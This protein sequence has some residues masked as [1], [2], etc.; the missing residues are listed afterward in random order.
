MAFRTAQEALAAGSP[1][2]G[3]LERIREQ[4]NR[5]HE[6]FLSAL[7][8][9]N[10]RTGQQESA[11]VGRQMGAAQGR[12]MGGGDVQGYARQQL[13]AMGMNDPREWDSLF[14]LW[15]KESGWNPNAVN[16]GSGAFGIAQILPSAHPTANRNMSAQEQIDWGLNYIRNR[17][18]SP[19]QAWAHSQRTNW[20]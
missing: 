1:D 14:R 20:Y 6:A 16:R 11:P 3:G 18:G 17:Y 15:Q 4:S 9:R 8:A 7:E 12:S 13:A 10:Q 2:L 19:S 5:Q